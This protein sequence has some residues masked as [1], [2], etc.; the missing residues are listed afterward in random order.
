MKETFAEVGLRALAGDYA[1]A[2]DVLA[3]AGHLF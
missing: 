3:V 2:M 1:A